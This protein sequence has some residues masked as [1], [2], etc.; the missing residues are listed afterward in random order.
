MN[1]LH[2]YDL[3]HYEKKYLYLEDFQFVGC[4]RIEL[5]LFL[6]HY[7]NIQGKIEDYYLILGGRGIIPRRSFGSG[8]YLIQNARILL[9][10]LNQKKVYLDELREYESGDTCEERL[11]KREND[12]FVK[13]SDLS[14]KTVEREKLYLKLLTL[15]ICYK[16]KQKKFAFRNGKRFGL[17]IDDKPV[18]IKLSSEITP[19]KLKKPAKK[20]GGTIKVSIKDLIKEAERIDDLFGKNGKKYRKRVLAN[21]TFKKVLNGTIR[22]T[23]YIEISEIV[24]V[25]GQVGAG[26]STF[27]KALVKYLAKENRK[28][29]LIQNSVPDV[30][31]M[32]ANLTQLGVKAVPVIGASH[33]EGHIKKTIDGKDFLSD[34]YSQI[35]TAG[36]PL[37]GLIEEVDVSISFGQE[38]CTRIYK[39]YEKGKERLNRLNTNERYICPYYYRCPRTKIQADI[40]EANVIVTTTAALS[41]MKVGIS[42]MT[43]FQYVLEYMDLV[44]VD[45]AERELQKADEIFAPYVPFDDYIRNNGSLYSDYYKKPSDERTSTD[46]DLRFFMHLHHESD[47]IFA[48]IDGLLKTNRHG[49]NRSRLERTF[50]GRL[51]INDCRENQKLPFDLCDELERMTNL[52]RDRKYLGILRDLVDVVT[53][54]QL[55]ESFR[56]YQWGTIE[57]LSQE[58]VYKVIF[59]AAV[60]YFEYLYREMSNLVEW[61]A[62]LPD[63]TKAILSQRFEFQQRYIPVSPIG[64]IFGLQY[65]SKVLNE[66]SDLCIVKQF[67]LGRAMYLRFPWLKLDDEG[68]PIGPHVLLLSGSS[69][70]PGSMANHINEPVNYIIEAEQYKRDFIKQS[71]FEHLMTDIYV[72]GSGDDRNVRLRELVLECKGLICEKLDEGHNIL[73]VVNSYEDT[74]IVNRALKNILLNTSYEFQTTHV[75]PDSDNSYVPEKIKQR[76][77]DTFISK[78]ARILV[79]PA[80]IIERGHNIVDEKGNAAFD[81]LIFLTRPM[82]RPDDYTSHVSKVN[83][84]IM[85]KYTEKYQHV[86]TECFNKMRAD[87]FNIYR[88]LDQGG[89]RLSDLDP[90]IQKDIVVTLFVMILQIFGRL[91]RIGNREDMKTRAPDVYFADAAFKANKPE[92][93]DLLNRLV[94]YLESILSDEHVN[95][96]VAKTLYEP[97]YLALKKGRNIYDKSE[98]AYLSDDD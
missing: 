80:I 51:L 73:M 62:Q 4:Q 49:F 90:L 12:K 18:E 50:S 35:L 64:N 2:L 32:C 54:E 43:L 91:C 15:N 55:L 85:S 79:A 41:T 44:I 74:I 19:I 13:V 61:N 93:F 96:E 76:E 37:G 10:T 77:L 3:K 97:F 31:K 9:K 7:L 21:T 83:G 47:R 5:L 38:P 23:S 22:H 75:V 57:E 95:V 98:N 11:Y 66:K 52:N 39:Y 30:L 1:R 53:K 82:Q 36:C 42:G 6:I 89:F 16:D 60:L 20:K 92:G 67:A 28:I 71:H 68:N 94:N 59:I 14:K 58:Q 34:Y 26:K 63:S 81:T 46:R 48:K 78:N 87:A 72:S 86:N 88:L 8:D 40:F 45:E 24:N 70:A 65:K 69:F 33:W 56:S 84:F 27:S 17:L 29:T 25:I